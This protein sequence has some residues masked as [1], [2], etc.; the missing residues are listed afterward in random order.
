MAPPAMVV[1][2]IELGSTESLGKYGASQS[3][4][5]VQSDCGVTAEKR[6]TGALAETPITAETGAKVTVSCATAAAVTLARP[7]KLGN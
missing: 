2:R 3:P 6:G 1:S 4:T 7:T 5:A